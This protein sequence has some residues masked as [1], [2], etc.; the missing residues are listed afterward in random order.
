[1]ICFFA[2]KEN[3]EHFPNLNGENFLRVMES[4]VQSLLRSHSWDHVG[5]VGKPQV[6]EKSRKAQMK[7]LRKR[8]PRWGLLITEKVRQG[9]FVSQVFFFSKPVFFFSIVESNCI[10]CCHKLGEF[11]GVFLDWNERTKPC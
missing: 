8:K 2:P 11:F 6:R 10:V 4:G 7:E 5:L 1:M 3:W 9:V